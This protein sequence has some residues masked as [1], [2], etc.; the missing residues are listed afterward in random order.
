M[1]SFNCIVCGKKKPISHAKRAKN[2]YCSH[3]CQVVERNRQTYDRFLEGT[4]KDRGTVRK[5]LL[6][7]KPQ[8]WECGTKEWRGQSLSLEV[9]HIDG[10][11]GNHV[12][13]NVRL[14]CPN[15]HSI[16]PNYKAKNKGKGRAARG[17]PLY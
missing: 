16:T 7:Q 15:C 12:P 10:N 2:I 1:P 4:V 5:I 17:L 3:T 13:S 11:A 14:L 6:E 8:C 9:D